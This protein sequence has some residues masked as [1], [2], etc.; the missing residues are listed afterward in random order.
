MYKVCTHD[1]LQRKVE[2]RGLMTRGQDR[3][4]LKG[5]T[6]NYTI[7]EKAFFASK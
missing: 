6:G 1:F 2:Y 4:A 3:V 5:S 7:L